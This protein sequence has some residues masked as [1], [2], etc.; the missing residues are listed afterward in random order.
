MRAIYPII[1]LLMLAGSAILEG[2][3]VR[4]GVSVL[5]LESLV[6]EIGG[7][8]VE[9]RSLQEEGDSC[10]VFEPRPSAIS[11]LSG[12]RLFF[13]VGAGYESVIIGKLESQFPER[14]IKDLRSEVEVLPLENHQGHHHHGHACET[15]HEEESTDPHIWLDPVRLA[16]LAEYIAIELGKLLPESS[17]SFQE[18]AKAFQ[19]R[20]LAV[21]EALVDQFHGS[22]G[23]GFYIYHPALGYFA[24]RF[25]LQQITIAVSSQ[26]PSARELHALIGQARRD[27]VK[28]IFVQPQESTRHAEIVAQA[29]GADL[30]TIDP[31]GMDLLGNLTRIGQALSESFGKE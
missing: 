15:C 23:K 27:K 10:S 11:W 7:D 9:V 22:E 16:V 18:S 28:T 5:P 19:R 30:V 2:A 1:F 8:Q 12:A 17:L 20:A 31:M 24:Q 4:I 14:A 26:G 29:I 25:G 6:K 21:H 3:P 13:R